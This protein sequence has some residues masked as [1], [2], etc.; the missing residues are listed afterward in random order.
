MGEPVLEDD[1][2]PVGRPKKQV[3]SALATKE[4][5]LDLGHHGV[6]THLPG[7]MMGVEMELATG[8]GGVLVRFPHRAPDGKVTKRTLLVPFGH[9]RQIELAE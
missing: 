8:V 4:G 7:A 3:V 2:R 9:L 5:G 6:K 1:K